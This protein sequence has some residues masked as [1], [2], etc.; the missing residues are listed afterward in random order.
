MEQLEQAEKFEAMHREQGIQE[1]LRNMPTG[2]SL[3]HCEEC[4]EPIPEARR[5]AAKGCTHC[6]ECAEFVQ[7]RRSGGKI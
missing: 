1:A 5:K 6:I 7:Q 2:E 4:G 3:T